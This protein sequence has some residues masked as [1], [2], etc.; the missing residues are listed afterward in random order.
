MKNLLKDIIDTATI[1]IFIGGPFAY[2]FAF[3]MKP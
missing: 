2:Y 3:M 1:A